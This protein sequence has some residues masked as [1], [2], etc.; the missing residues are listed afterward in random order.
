MPPRGE[1]ATPEAEI[2]FLPPH[3]SIG[4][5][6][7]GGNVRHKNLNLIIGTFVIGDPTSE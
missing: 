5:G 2:D 3:L 7:L 6:S 4:L 1:I